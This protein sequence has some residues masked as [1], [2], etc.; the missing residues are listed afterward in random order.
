MTRYRALSLTRDGRSDLSFVEAATIEEAAAQLIAKGATPIDVRLGTPS[1][2]ERL[3]QPVVARARL[4]P[5]DLALVTEQ[6]ATLLTAGLP[7]ERALDLL[8]AQPATRSHGRFS[9]NLLTSI[10]AGRSFADALAAEPGVPSYYI[11]VVRAA[12]RGGRL[13]DGLSDLA[14]TLRRSESVRQQLVAALTYPAIV[15][16]TSI[17]ALFIVLTGVIP[18][19]E[20]IFAGEEHRL[21]WLTRAVLALSRLVNN[22]GGLL[23]LGFTIATLVALLALRQPAARQRLGALA[24]RLPGSDLARRHAAARLLRVL[25]SMLSNGVPLAEA[26]ELTTGRFGWRSLVQAAA[27]SVREGAALSAALARDPRFPRT[28]VRLIEVGEESGDLAG[29]SLHAAGLLETETRA[30][31]DRVVAIANPVAVIL[32]GG[33]VALL[34]MGVMLGIFS[35]N[36]LAA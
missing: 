2:V 36:E 1:L 23:L 19:F 35:V 27:Q 6:I 10:R 5:A 15:L 14:G 8:A 13:R 3:N 11:G 25:G 29:M 7:L 16:A 26:L 31:V 9:S 20:P 28:A 4:R 12:E 34:I 18:E 30:R 33:L 17:G 24:A 22:H 21:P 32:L